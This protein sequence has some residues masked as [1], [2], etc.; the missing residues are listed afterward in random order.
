MAEDQPHMLPTDS[1]DERPAAP[2]DENN[3]F[4]G[5][6]QANLKANLITLFFLVL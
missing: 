6:E 4:K 1:G 5:Q 3:A 2:V